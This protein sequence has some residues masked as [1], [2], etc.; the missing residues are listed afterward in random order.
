MFKTFKVIIKGGIKHIITTTP[1]GGITRI[2]TIKKETIKVWIL[3]YRKLYKKTNLYTIHNRI[4]YLKLSNSNSNLNR[5]KVQVINNRKLKILI[6]K[7]L[8]IFQIL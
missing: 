8:L 7:T 5:S 3:I 6:F 1:E 2:T 4:L